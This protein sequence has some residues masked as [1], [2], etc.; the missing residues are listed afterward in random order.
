MRK[1][2]EKI[3]LRTIK[4]SK[5]NLLVLIFATINFIIYKSKTSH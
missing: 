5:T 4:E 2:V 1:I 3:K